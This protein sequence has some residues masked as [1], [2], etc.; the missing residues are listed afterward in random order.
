MQRTKTVPNLNVEAL[1]KELIQSTH[2][3]ETVQEQKK[4][5]PKQPAKMEIFRPNP[6]DLSPETL[7][8]LDDFVEEAHEL[9]TN[10]CH[11]LKIGVTNPV[12][13][14]REETFRYIHTLRSNAQAI[15]LS[16]LPNLAGAAEN[17]LEQHKGPIL[18]EHRE[19]LLSVQDGIERI[20]N[21]LSQN[22]RESQESHEDITLRLKKLQA[23]T[24]KVSIPTTQ[25]PKPTKNQQFLKVPIR[26]LNR[27]MN[28]SSELVVIKNRLQS[29]IHQAPPELEDLYNQLK[30]ISREMQD[31][32]GTARLQPIAIAFRKVPKIV[33]EASKLTKKKVIVQF[34]GEELR[35][36]KSLLDQLQEPLL[37]IVRNSIDHGIENAAVRQAAQKPKEGLLRIVAAVEGGMF[38]LRIH[39]DGGGV[40]FDKICR[41]AI[42]EGIYSIED[43]DLLSPQQRQNLLFHPGLSSKDE[44]NELSGRGMG[45]DIVK[46]RIEL[47]RGSIQIQSTLGV[48]T[49]INIQV[50]L[51]V[52]ILQ[53]LLIPT[54]NTPVLIPQLRIQEVRSIEA[55]D[56]T[57]IENK[58]YYTLGENLLPTISLSSILDQSLPPSKKII[59]CTRGTQLFGIE[60]PNIVGF[61]EVVSHPLPK[62]LTSIHLYQGITILENGLPALIF[63]LDFIFSTFDLVGYNRT[64]QVHVQ[65]NT[66]PYIVFAISSL[67]AIPL[68]QVRHVSKL[69]EEEITPCSGWEILRYAEEDFPLVEVYD[70]MS[71]KKDITTSYSYVL[72][73]SNDTNIAVPISHVK[74]IFH[75]TQ[76]P[77]TSLKRNGVLGTIQYENSPVEIIDINIF[78]QRIAQSYVS[79]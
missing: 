49:T 78:H 27:M 77:D 66:I 55:T 36:D 17:L 68:K 63:N 9:L 61:Q 74:G 1:R 26:S 4:P 71:S 12:E 14:E 32:I 60:T 56:V 65:S 54:C 43:I 33:R 2:T 37:H 46:N 6:I 19:A 18:E 70:I 21:N 58:R 8:I 57:V 3:I 79:V 47:L 40:D 29:L 7:E 35:L 34:E 73:F 11:L 42:E 22:Q 20:L 59:I 67:M 16:T 51:S 31:E 10:Y 69:D 52:R 28:L 13:Q 64:T 30:T 5:S 48:G 62:Y 25:P 39:D 38:C 44:A 24:S 41:K 50:P 75:T 15:G 76:K 53:T 23:N 45:M 72:L